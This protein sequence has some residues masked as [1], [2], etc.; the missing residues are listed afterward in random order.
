MKLPRLLL[1]ALVAFVFLSTVNAVFA[2]ILFPDGPQGYYRNPRL[3]PL[4]AFRLAAVLLIAFLMAYMFPMGYK[5][6]KTTAEGLRFG[7]LIGLLI[8]LPTNLNLYAV[9]EV[10]FDGLLTV[11]LWTIITAGIAGAIIARVY[12]KTLRGRKT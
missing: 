10:R 4:T 1:S 11:V 6:G 5:G 9:A 3:E 7:M 2:P 8:G 12:G